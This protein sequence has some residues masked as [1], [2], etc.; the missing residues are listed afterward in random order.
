MVGFFS[1]CGKLYSLLSKDYS[2]ESPQDK[3]LKCTKSIVENYFLK[4]AKGGIKLIV[5]LKFFQTRE[6]SLD[7]I[8]EPVKL[9]FVLFPFL[10][11]FGHLFES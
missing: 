10:L 6:Q 3:F 5:D 8:N 9:R 7:F 2:V 11:N 4:M 1:V